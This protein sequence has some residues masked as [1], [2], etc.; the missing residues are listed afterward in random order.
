MFCRHIVGEYRV[1]YFENGW[2]SIYTGG[3]LVDDYYKNGVLVLD[4]NKWLVFLDES[5]IDT[6]LLLK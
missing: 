3:L 1:Y 2:T 6:M 5:R 4:L